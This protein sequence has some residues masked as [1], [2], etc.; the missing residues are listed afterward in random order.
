MGGISTYAVVL[1]AGTGSRM[2]AGQPKQFLKVAGK[3]I[4]ERTVAAFEAMDAVDG[5]VV[6]ANPDFMPR[7]GELLAGSAFAKVRAV[8]AG[9]ATRKDSSRAGVERVRDLAGGEANVL[10]HDCARPFV[11][12]RVV[13]DCLRA[14]ESCPA[15]DVAVPVT[16]TVVEIEGGRIRRIPAREALM[17]SQTPQGFRLSLIRRAHEL[18]LGAEGFTD[19]VS[20]VVRQG[21]APV[22]VVAGSANNI[23]ITHPGDIFVAER[24]LREGKVPDRP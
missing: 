11:D 5:I 12:E 10:I 13:G 2:G 16:D 3:T 23:K 4:F 19:D 22:A 6:V 9:G 15:V 20:L 17:A 18:A 7:Y 14:L 1:A 8:V 24:L 21:L